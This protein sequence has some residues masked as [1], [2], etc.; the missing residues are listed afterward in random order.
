MTKETSTIPYSAENG[1][2]KDEEVKAM[3]KAFKLLRG[4]PLNFG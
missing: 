2:Q 1:R 3:Q 4:E